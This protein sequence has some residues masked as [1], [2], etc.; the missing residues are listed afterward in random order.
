MY[1]NQSMYK[2]LLYMH[3]H[4]FN[5]KWLMVIRLHLYSFVFSTP[6]EQERARKSRCLFNYT[7]SIYS[8]WILFPIHLAFV[9]FLKLF[10]IVF[11]P[12]FAGFSF[13]FVAIAVG[14]VSPIFLFFFQ[15]VICVCL[16]ERISAPNESNSKHKKEHR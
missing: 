2:V 12:S 14:F 15:V 5:A 3:I 4:T 11:S 10:A 16:Y 9:V 8:V 1:V 6:A 7:L 13:S